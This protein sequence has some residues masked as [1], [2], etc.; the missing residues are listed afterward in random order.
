MIGGLTIGYIRR[1]A[2]QCCM[3]GYW[4]GE[5][6]AGQGH[7]VAALQL[8]IPYIFS[9]LQLH[10]I[11]AA[12]IPEN[13]RSIRLLEKAGFQREGYLRDY[14]KINGQWRDHLMFSLLARDGDPTENPT[15]MTVVSRRPCRSTDR[16]LLLRSS[17]R[18]TAAMLLCRY[19]GMAHA[20]EPVK[21][22]RED[23]ALDLT[24]TT[25]IYTNQGEA[26]QV[27]TAAGTD[28]I[29]AASRCAPAPKPSGRLGGLRARQRFGRTARARHR[30]PAFPAGEFQDVLAGPRLAAH[31]RRSRRAKAS[32]STGS[33]AT[34]PTS[35]ASRS[36]PVRSSP[37]SPNS[38]RRTCRRSISGSRTPTRTRSTPSRSIAASCSALPACWRC[39]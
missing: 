38:P 37:S 15:V 33:R 9:S 21:I 2:A 17:R 6:H 5:R 7:M 8:V 35:S 1:G 25:E 28:G 39:S 12:C 19:A 32:R 27:S 24:A 20:A 31:H 23:T 14:L 22:S 16:R 18:L 30:R 3:I 10:R 11:E 26:F 36:I 13:E 4:M 29:A 34:R